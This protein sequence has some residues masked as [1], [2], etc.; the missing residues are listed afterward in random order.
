MSIRSFSVLSKSSDTVMF[1]APSVRSCMRA[2]TASSDVSTVQLTSS[3]SPPAIDPFGESASPFCSP[4]VPFSPPPFAVVFSPAVE[5]SPFSPFLVRLLR[6]PSVR[7]APWLAGFTFGG[8][9]MMNVF[10]LWFTS[11]GPWKPHALQP[12]EIVPFLD[13][14]IRSVSGL[15]HS[16]HSTNLRMNPSSRSCSLAASCE[17]FTM[18][19][20]PLL[21]LAGQIHLCFFATIVADRTDDGRRGGG[22]ASALLHQQHVGIG[23]NGGVFTFQ[24]NAGGGC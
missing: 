5:S 11:S 15:S 21:L 17:P 7:D 4:L 24:S 2:R 6:L 14:T 16:G 20:K 23:V 19:P 12:C 9:L 8:F 18:K 1:F 3:T 22:C 10:T 13:E